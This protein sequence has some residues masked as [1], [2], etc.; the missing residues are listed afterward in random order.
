M[1]FKY[2]HKP[3]RG[4][5]MSR[6]LVYVNTNPSEKHITIHLENKKACPYVFQ[7]L[8]RRNT[9]GTLSIEDLSNGKKTAIKFAESGG[10]NSYWIIIWDES[11]DILNNPII[12]KI[13]DT[14]K[15]RV[16]TCTT[17]SKLV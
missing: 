16:K 13:A 12:K 6:Y 10:K 2:T 5:Y 11:E 3:I 17:C 7:Q 1:Y 8:L 15:V 14:L 4:E 9:P